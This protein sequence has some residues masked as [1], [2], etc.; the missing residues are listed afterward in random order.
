MVRYAFHDLILEVRQ[1]A[2]A[3]DTQ[4][5]QQLLHDL[6]WS[7]GVARAEP[8][9]RS[10]SLSILPHQRDPVV[11]DTAREV[12][13]VEG[14][15]GLEDGGDFYLT[16]GASLF[17]LSH[18]QRLAEVRL[19][20]SFFHKPQTLRQSFWAFGLLK[21]LRVEGIFSLH[22]AGV[23]A[24]DGDGILLVAEPGSGK[25]TLTIGLVRKGW[26]YLSDDAVLLR[27]RPEGVEAMALRRHFYVD[28]S[29]AGEYADLG[30][31]GEKPDR[32]GRP[33]RRVAVAASY[34]HQYVSACTPQVLLFPRIVPD[35]QSILVPLDPTN[36]LRRLLTQS[37]LQLFDRATSARHF[38]VLNQLLQQATSYELRSGADLKKEPMKLARMLLDA[39]GQ[40]RC[41]A[42]S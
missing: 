2:A 35:T 5:L 7:E 29:A 31:D 38:A 15:R 10:L 23:V 27:S 21:L 39:K 25:S 41:L 6:S 34:P 26:R 8:G 32:A 24:D 14:F 3:E 19:A 18:G 37:G 16:D 13:N 33:R 17:R 9:Q 12:L 20:A 22:T 42:S 28:S 40:E 30:L 11:P 36:A 1:N 4:G